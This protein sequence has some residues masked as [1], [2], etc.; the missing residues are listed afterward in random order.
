MTSQVALFY[1]LCTVFQC[2]HNSIVQRATRCAAVGWNLEHA[3]T[4]GFGTAA[5]LS[6]LLSHTGIPGL[7]DWESFAQTSRAARQAR[8]LATCAVRSGTARLGSARLNQD[9]DSNRSGIELSLAV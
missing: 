8:R 6:N 7:L 3:R 9:N 5:Q 1:L 2:R 4:E